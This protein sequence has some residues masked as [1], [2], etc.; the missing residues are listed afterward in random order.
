MGEN[1]IPVIRPKRAWGKEQWNHYNRMPWMARRLADLMVLFP[2]LSGW[3]LRPAWRV[4]EKHLKRID[5]DG[6][7]DMTSEQ[8]WGNKRTGTR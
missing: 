5:H 4:E 6:R 2:R 8:Q 7:H 3:V 1:D